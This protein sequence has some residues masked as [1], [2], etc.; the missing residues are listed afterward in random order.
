M[1]E[2]KPWATE[3]QK[4]YLKLLILMLLSQKSLHGYEIM[5]KVEEK[6]LGLWRPTAGGVYPILKRMEK[7][8][9]VKGEWTKVQGK[10]RR[11]YHITVEGK[12]ILNKA[13]EKQKTMADTVDRLYSEF[14]SEFLDI[15]PSKVPKLPIFRRF[16]QY[17][18]MEVRSREEKIKCLTSV[19]THIEDMIKRMQIC[20][21]EINRKLDES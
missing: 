14:A 5:D 17:G 2:N 19:K 10:R 9:Q 11:I 4:G 1:S 3:L 13:L 7:R 12:N 15:P 8:N 16:F 21:R 6:T 18:C 20:L